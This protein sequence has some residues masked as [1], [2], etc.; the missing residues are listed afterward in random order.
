MQKNRSK[1][2]ISILTLILGMSALHAETT[3]IMPLG[4]SITYDN[5][6]SDLEDPRPTSQ[7]TSYRNHLW[8]KLSNVGYAADFVGTKVAGQGVVPAFDPDNE[9]HPGWTSNDIAERVYE[10]LTLN[11]ADII[12]LHIGTND[13]SSSSIGVESLLN[14]VNLYET[15]SAKDVRVIVA[16]IIDTQSQN[17]ETIRRFNLNLKTMVGRRIANGDNLTL[18]DMYRG[19]GLTGADYDDILHPND[20]GYQKMAEVWFQE[21]K[22][23]YNSELTAFPYRL[24]DSAY[25]ESSVVDETG[26]SVIFTTKIPES[27]I[28]F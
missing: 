26:T 1:F 6:E 10:Y 9:G 19:A 8:Y 25:I 2:L 27:G 22:K 13:H 23:P 24:V 17:N 20:S 3:T 4:D 5:R 12:L 28:T 16:I 18:V 11:H 14:E 15:Q 21:I 7:R